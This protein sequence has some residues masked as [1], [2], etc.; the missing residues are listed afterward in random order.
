MVHGCWDMTTKSP[1]FQQL[2]LACRSGDLERVDQLITTSGVQINQVDEW[3]YS[4]LILASL[5]GHL[6]I[7]DFLLQRGAVCDRDTFEGARCIYG[8]LTDEI[9]NILLSYDISKS[10]DTTQPFASHFANIHSKPK[11]ITCDLLLEFSENS[12]AL[13]RFML[14]AR[15]N[16]EFFPKL[17]S[18]E[19]ANS[20]AVASSLNYAAWSFIIA[21]IYLIPSFAIEKLSGEE[22]QMVR[23]MG[24]QLAMD[25]LVSAVDLLDTNTSLSATEVSKLKHDIQYDQCEAARAGLKRFVDQEIFSRSISS[26]TLSGP[27]KKLLLSSKGYADI[28]V[29]IDTPSG[30]TYY[31]LHR[32]ILVRSEYFETMF[33]SQFSEATVYDELIN[34]THNVVDRNML[35]DLL[36]ELPVITL[37]LDSISATSSFFEP[38]RMTEI[39][40]RYLYF[41]EAIIPYELS[42][43]M[44]FLADILFI[45]KLKTMAAVSLTSRP[46]IRSSPTSETPFTLFDILRAGWETR[47]HRLEQFVA[48]CISD[49]LEGFVAMSEFQQVVLESSERIEIRQ[50][51]DTIE[52]IDD[53][54]YYLGKK[55][56]IDTQA[57]E[58]FTP[59]SIGHDPMKNVYTA[60]N[61]VQYDRDLERVEELLTALGLDA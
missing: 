29:T 21:Y 59:E 50:D 25:D 52:L 22:I 34:E 57:D 39:L 12:T 31:P 19:W 58:T 35:V 33:Q 3:D 41:D 10:V 1:E 60:S 23:E 51:T 30:K 18:G 40:I 61:E 24:S 26:K 2:L 55:Y 8:A 7:V 44:L 56:S 27:E 11:L 17:L 49:D 42:L 14:V 37:P 28:I 45:D 38:V 5:C 46:P 6:K 47:V 15:T 9:R 16:S 20:V 13:H 43:D 54:R 4:P 53:I 48:K 36:D 32:A